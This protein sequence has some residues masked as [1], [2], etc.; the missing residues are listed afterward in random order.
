MSHQY[1]PIASFTIL[2]SICIFLLQPNYIL[3]EVLPSKL[4]IVSC[5]FFHVAPR[6]FFLSVITSCHF[7]VGYTFIC[8]L[9]SISFVTSL[10]QAPSPT[11]D[12]TRGHLTGI[13]SCPFFLTLGPL[14][15]LVLLPE[16]CS[17]PVK[18]LFILQDPLKYPFHNLPQSQLG[19]PLFS[20]Q[21]LT[22]FV[23]MYAVLG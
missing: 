17:P 11:L 20:F 7:S 4:S 15:V 3:F 2:K 18:P 10:V 19:T 1:K 22:Q 8:S 12:Q 14:H 23:F 21:H 5:P 9:V 13:H 16:M 6:S